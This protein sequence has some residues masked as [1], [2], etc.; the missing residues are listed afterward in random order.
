MTENKTPVQQIEELKSFDPIIYAKG[1]RKIIFAK[2]NNRLFRIVYSTSH[3]RFFVLTPSKIEEMT[4]DDVMNILN[5]YA[6]NDAQVEEKM[7]YFLTLHRTFTHDLVAYDPKQAPFLYEK[8]CQIITDSLA[9]KN[10]KKEYIIQPETSKKKTLKTVAV[11]KQEK[12]QTVSAVSNTTGEAPL[13]KTISRTAEKPTASPLAGVSSVEKTIKSF[14]VKPVPATPV[15]SERDGVPDTKSQEAKT[16]DEKQYYFSEEA[17]RERIRANKERWAQTGVV[18]LISNVTRNAKTKKE[19]KDLPEMKPFAQIKAPQPAPSKEVV[20]DEGKSPKKTVIHTRNVTAK[21]NRWTA[22][23]TSVVETPSTSVATPAPIDPIS[24]ITSASGEVVSCED[25]KSVVQLK[26]N[27]QISDDIHAA[28]E[29]NSLESKQG[30]ETTE[31]I[32]PVQ[33]MVTPSAMPIPD[34]VQSG[35]ETID[36]KVVV[37]P[38]SEDEFHLLNVDSFV[39]NETVFEL[40]ANI[41]ST[42]VETDLLEFYGMRDVAPNFQSFYTIQSLKKAISLNLNDLKNPACY[43]F[44]FMPQ[45]FDNRMMVFKQGDEC[46]SLSVNRK[47]PSSFIRNVKTGK[48]RKLAWH[49]IEQILQKLSVHLS[50]LNTP[51]VYAKFKEV[52]NSTTFAPSTNFPTVMQALEEHALRS[53][54]KKWQVSDI[55]ATLCS[56]RMVIARRNGK[57]YK[58]V[59]SD[60]AV[61][62]VYDAGKV[63]PMTIDEFNR[64]HRDLL[65]RYPLRELKEHGSVAIRKRY[66]VKTHQPYAPQPVY[67]VK[68]DTSLDLGTQ[69]LNLK[70]KPRRQYQSSSPEETSIVNKKGDVLQQGMEP[71]SSVDETK[72]VAQQTME[73]SLEAARY[74]YAPDEARPDFKFEATL[75][76]LREAYA[77][78]NPDAAIQPINPLIDSQNCLY[79]RKEDTTYIISLD[80]EN[81]LFMKKVNDAL[82]PLPLPETERVLREIIPD[83][84]QADFYVQYF[85]EVFNAH[86]KRSI[87]RQRKE[88]PCV[89]QVLEQAR[90]CSLLKN[91]AALTDIQPTI[92]FGNIII[93]KKGDVFYKITLDKLTYGAYENGVIRT[94]TPDEVRYINGAL[95]RNYQPVYMQKK[96]ANNLIKGYETGGNPQEYY[97]AVQKREKTKLEMFVDAFEMAIQQV[98]AVLSQQKES[99]VDTGMDDAIK[100]VVEPVVTSVEVEVVTEQ[101][102]VVKTPARQEVKEV[103]V[104]KNIEVVNY[105]PQLKELLQ[106][107]DVDSD[108]SAFYNF[109]EN[110]PDFDT[111]YQIEVLKR[112][113]LNNNPDLSAQENSHFDVAPVYTNDNRIHCIIGEKHYVVSVMPEDVYFGVN[114]CQTTARWRLGENGARDILMQIT[115]SDK[116]LQQAVLAQLPRL[117]GNFA[118]QKK[119]KGRPFKSL[120][121]FDQVMEEADLKARL[122]G[123]AEPRDIAA[124]VCSGGLICARYDGIYY[125]I[126]LKGHPTFEV[127]D[128]GVVRNMRKHEFNRI[129]ED[130]FNGP[131]L[132]YLRRNRIVLFQSAYP[133]SEQREVVIKPKPQVSLSAF[134]GN[135]V[136]PTDLPMFHQLLVGKKETVDIPATHCVD[137]CIY[138]RKNGVYFKINLVEPMQFT[139]LE[140]G[141][142]R[143]MT[144]SEFNQLLN[145]F[146]ATYGDEY[147]QQLNLSDLPAVFEKLQNLPNQAVETEQAEKTDEQKTSDETTDNTSLISAE[148]EIEPGAEQP[149]VEAVRVLRRSKRHN[150]SAS[151]ELQPDQE[152]R[153]SSPVIQPEPK[154][155]SD[156]LPVTESSVS[157]PEKEVQIPQKYSHYDIFE[158]DDLDEA[159]TESAAEK[160]KTLLFPKRDIQAVTLAI[161]PVAVLPSV[162]EG[163]V[164]LPQNSEF[165]PP[166][167]VLPDF[168]T[169][170]KTRIYQA[171]LEIGGRHFPHQE[172]VLSFDISP[173]LC[174]NHILFAKKNNLLYQ[175][176]L[177]TE[178][179]RFV[180][181]DLVTQ[182]EY[183]MPLSKVPA[184]LDEWLQDAQKAAELTAILSPLHAQYIAQGEIKPFKRVQPSFQQ[185]FNLYAT[186]TAYLEAEGAL[187]KTSAKNYFHIPTT[188]CA[189]NTLYAKS[190]CLYYKIQVAEPMVFERFNGTETCLMTEPELE[191]MLKSALKTNAFPKKTEMQIV[192][193]LRQSYKETIEPIF[194]IAKMD[195]IS[196]NQY[197]QLLASGWLANRTGVKRERG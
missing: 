145:D 170:Y 73:Q 52:H 159:R 50:S 85:Q 116:D 151:R 197:Q 169:M 62:E 112:A 186:R 38:K 196:L 163:M 191:A 148:K 103:V 113:I 2:Q 137:N 25:I 109:N 78:Q 67:M 133:I 89:G 111:L 110:A 160:L 60:V 75:H 136:K 180:I 59:L 18:D 10:V 5:N 31:L 41:V 55:P 46:V 82:R 122:N 143:D 177:D 76:A 29:N 134:I 179:P 155:L 79:Y 189:D 150:F 42:P 194:K 33:S 119:K 11:K 115:K 1:K 66:M 123:V 86:K 95:W 40:P 173:I 138:A 88:I 64:F 16:P 147:R 114:V 48:I 43:D 90:Y 182:K 187:P 57:Y 140:A 22:A 171:R 7:G 49:E 124:T 87:R 153:Q 157:E 132:G 98:S 80:A 15:V 152:T 178:N 13:D 154:E 108:L 127:L 71:L 9:F 184:I 96:G 176:S 47:Q 174:N 35:L 63:T 142:I 3:P 74:F 156:K 118:T 77:V 125:K 84:R 12:V 183:L 14:E 61:F 8:S 65:T 51:S 93:A 27:I 44:D 162:P 130:I 36:E 172:D 53:F 144:S 69:I 102:P 56:G 19:K 92:C 94:M 106:V 135:T 175:V 168:E 193:L 158:E 141:E 167:N 146:N 185:V 181:R 190:G 17:T 120:P 139:V 26:K 129:R 192:T 164:A 58:A 37:L 117:L 128:M 126:S 4:Q 165:F 101:I 99:S 91:V 166:V 104:D 70:P 32:T 72:V 68:I 149:K 54:F 23:S 39:L 105:M 97:V 121:R 161:Y 34:E 107:N 188:R 100:S 195:Q 24:S 21:L 81:P 28:L 6:G 83:V 20:S 30:M 45:L 131:V